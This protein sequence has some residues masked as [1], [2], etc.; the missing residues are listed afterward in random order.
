MSIDEISNKWNLL[1]L[2]EVRKQ[3]NSVSLLHGTQR[4]VTLNVYIE[5]ILVDALEL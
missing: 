1:G 3:Y 2:E 5:I 4:L